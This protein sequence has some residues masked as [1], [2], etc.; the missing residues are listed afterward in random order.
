MVRVLL[1]G[2]LTIGSATV[3]F[4][5]KE[6]RVVVNRSNS[7]FDE[8]I[9]TDTEHGKHTLMRT[10]Q[11]WEALELRLLYDNGILEIFANERFAL[12]TRLYGGPCKIRILSDDGDGFKRA[13]RW[14]L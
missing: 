9:N 2:E 3:Q 1:L 8:D 7:S 12:S 5:P 14:E 13:R 4:H 6:E 11:G 10:A